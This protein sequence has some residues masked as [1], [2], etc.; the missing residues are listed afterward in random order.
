MVG[1]PTYAIN[2]SRRSGQK[3]AKHILLR[4]SSL[5]LAVILFLSLSFLSLSRLVPGSTAWWFD[6][7]A[8]LL[9]LSCLVVLWRVGWTMLRDMSFFRS[10]V[11]PQSLHSLRHCRQWQQATPI[12]KVIDTSLA[13]LAEQGYET[14]QQSLADS[15]LICAMRGKMNRLGFLLTHLA[16]PMVIIAVLMDSNLILNYR[17]WQG[18]VVAAVQQ[19]ATHE[20]ATDSR[21][22]AGVAGAF[23]G[24]L[25][26]S[27]GEA[28]DE[29][30]LPLA[31]GYVVQQLPFTLALEDVRISHLEREANDGFSSQLVIRDRHRSEPVQ[32][33]LMVN[34]PLQYG[35]LTISQQQLF[36]G[37][38]E[39][40]VQVWPLFRAQTRPLKMKLKIDTSRELRTSDSSY[41][42]HL[43]DFLPRNII[44]T[45]TKDFYRKNYK[46]IGPSL[47]YSVTDIDD[48]RRN[49]VVYML[50][51]LQDGRYFYL[52]K[53]KRA[54]EDEFRYFHMPADENGELT[55]FLS[56][57]AALHDQ[58]VVTRYVKDYVGSLPLARQQNMAQGILRLISEFNQGGYEAVENDVRAR[59]GGE[60]AD[61]S[62]VATFKILRNIIYEIYNK[63]VRS[64]AKSDASSIIYAE[65]FFADAMLALDRL[66]QYGVPFYLQLVDFE[67]RPAV[68]LLVSNKPGRVLLYSGLFA[69]LLGLVL[70]L[71]SHYRRLWLMLQTDDTAVSMILAGMSHRREHLFT[72]EFSR[73]ATQLQDSLS[74]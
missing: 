14:R 31:D 51:A 15:V 37:G 13:Y 6:L 19:Q 43:D 22:R 57:Q 10:S 2:M 40:R 67:Y 16:L 65:Q 20:V 50:P 73:L 34:R 74:T 39:M 72:S 23:R 70:L 42:F 58:R 64:Q 4:A 24:T 29:V 1:R 33:Q 11:S 3:F 56:L 5:E 41:E 38:S 8:G 44:A 49:Y 62:T 27:A 54:D 36:D 21:Q 55:Q 7:L 48:V 60:D 63:E 32:G 45:N 26:L 28:S 68:Q 71:F 59:F 52:S 46:N 66:G 25:V 47:H 30:R 69:G 17:L 61:K 9:V 53:S 12:A 18:D 35:G